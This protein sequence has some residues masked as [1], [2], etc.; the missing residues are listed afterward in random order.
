ML[1]FVVE[2]NTVIFENIAKKQLLLD[3]NLVTEFHVGKFGF[4]IRYA[5]EEQVKTMASILNGRLLASNLLEDETLIESSKQELDAFVA[6]YK[7]YKEIQKIDEVIKE[8]RSILHEAEQLLTKEE[9]RA[10]FLE[11]Y[12]KPVTPQLEVTMI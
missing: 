2:V 7:L 11:K 8:D 4:N 1:E 5:S 6:S 9:K 10:H 12:K 3:K